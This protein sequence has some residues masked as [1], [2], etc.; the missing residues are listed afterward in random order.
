MNLYHYT[1]QNGLLGI[2]KN[3]EIWATKIQYL[4]DENEYRLANKLAQRAL[5]FL[6]KNKEYSSHEFRIR[7]FLA[8]L[9]NYQDN[10]LCVCSLS[11]HGD[12]LSQWRGYARSHG[13]YSIGFDK[14]ELQKVVEGKGYKLV[15]CIYNESEQVQAITKV[16]LD[17]L[18]KFIDFDEPNQDDVH[19]SSDS[20]KYFC[21]QLSCVSS[22][23]KD[24]SFKE[25]AEWRIVALVRF[26]NLEFRPGKSM[27][28]P[29]TRISLD[30]SPVNL[31]S[32]FIVGHTPHAFL[33][34]K[35]TQAFLLSQFPPAENQT[36]ECIFR[37]KK[38]KIPY[39]SW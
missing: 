11:E 15:K 32:E 10:N 6:L 12:L 27:L 34:E 38:S 8:S 7:R 24:S 33:A 25:E 17:S 35:A 13:G 2:I 9:D 18:E 29:F 23:I 39:R 30:S 4:N 36:Y 5:E 21:N 22:Y 1:D 14:D 20:S 37:V 26:Q 3:K 19:V 31:F 16:I 28:I